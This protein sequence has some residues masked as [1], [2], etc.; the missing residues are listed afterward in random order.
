MGLH[1]TANCV[2]FLS[3]PGIRKLLGYCPSVEMISKS[4]SETS[5]SDDWAYSYT[6]FADGEDDI[7]FDPFDTDMSPY[8]VGEMASI[9]SIIQQN[10]WKEFY[11]KFGLVRSLLAA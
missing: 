5:T 11:R 10:D 4:R 1:G 8:S 7:E 9:S 6:A 2:I 3:T